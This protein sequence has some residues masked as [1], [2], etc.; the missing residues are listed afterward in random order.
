MPQNDSITAMKPCASTWMALATRR[1]FQPATKLTYCS[2][3]EAKARPAQASMTASERTP[4]PMHATDAVRI[5]PN[6][7]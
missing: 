1:M 5:Q 6:C 2:S 7:L 3:R 4:R